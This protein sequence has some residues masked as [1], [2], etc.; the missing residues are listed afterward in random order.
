M[1]TTAPAR[2][3]YSRPDPGG[4]TRRWGLLSTVLFLPAALAAAVLA[5][6]SEQMSRCVEYAQE[7]THGMPGPVFGW[8]AGVADAALLV[9]L[10]AT[11]SRVR[12]C[13][14]C[15]QILAEA[16]ALLVVVSHA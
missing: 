11:T 14:L 8:A 4:G 7:C 5:L 15:V 3:R 13:A 16:A 12:E 9:V 2:A 1:N 10:A 6:S